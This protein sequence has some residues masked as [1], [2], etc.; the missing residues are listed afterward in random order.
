MR[1]LSLAC[2]APAA[3]AALLLPVAGASAATV[4]FPYIDV[5][6]IGTPTNVTQTNGV[7]SV[8]AT[9]DALFTALGVST[10]FTPA[11][12]FTLM[13]TYN[14]ALTAA[15][16]TANTYDFSN[17]AITVNNG[18]NLLTATFSDLKISSLS[19]SLFSIAIG[20]GSLTYT[21]GSLAGTLTQGQVVGTFT[22]NTFTPNGNSQPDLS[23]NFTGTNF[24]AKVGAV[25]PL[26]GTLALLLPG[27]LGLGVIAR[28]KAAV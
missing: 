10:P 14:A 12:T 17:G 1:N 11:A 18:T 4:P 21:G 5:I 27:L 22:L 9:G 6:T 26:P 19:T 2:A 24:T 7:L 28:R 16:T 20:S 3:L 15:E 23:Q 25:V 13:G 8:T